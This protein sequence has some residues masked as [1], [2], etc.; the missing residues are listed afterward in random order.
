MKI[1]TLI[2]ALALIINTSNLMATN[3]EILTFDK[4]KTD[5]DGL[6]RN[7]RDLTSFNINAIA[8][9]Q[10]SE[11]ELKIVRTKYADEK[12]IVVDLRRES[13][14]LVNGKP[15]SWRQQFDQS[16]QGKSTQEIEND[17][18]NRI[19]K[20][21]KNEK[22]LIYR[23]FQKDKKN[24]WYNNVKPE[25][26]RVED[27]ESENNLVKKYGFSY[28]RFAIKDHSKPEDKQIEE[29][30]KFIKSLPKNQ[31]IYVHCAA[32]KGR[33][34]TFLT[35]YDII[36]NSDKKTLEEILTRQYEA[37]GS[38]LDKID[39]YDENWR[40]NLAQEKFEMIKKFYESQ[41]IKK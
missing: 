10:F 1:K 33:T 37:G 26:I 23:I 6:P 15:V 38:K 12:I 34:T 27:V 20:I 39:N 30:V 18:K 2:I 31:K 17:E 40:K 25:I 35:L 19:T 13:H 11:E 3:I 9:G 24:G 41:K 22:I 16:N 7:F 4:N 21:K 29:M 5:K 32:G 36:Q 14:V 28:K 8:S